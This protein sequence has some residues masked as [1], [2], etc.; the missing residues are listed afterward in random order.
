MQK[1]AF[2][3]YVKNLKIAASAQLCIFDPADRAVARDS[4]DNN[5]GSVSS[6]MSSPG[7][8]SCVQE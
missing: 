8:G 1:V 6:C 3:H 5:N 4:N 7:H 2:F